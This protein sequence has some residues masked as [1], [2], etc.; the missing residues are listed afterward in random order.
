MSTAPQTNIALALMEDKELAKRYYAKFDPYAD[1]DTS[2]DTNKSVEQKD[3]DNKDAEKK[4]TEKKD[5][6]KE[7]GKKATDKEMGNKDT[8]KDDG[9]MC[10]VC[11][12]VI[13]K[14][15]MSTCGHA[16]CAQ[17]VNQLAQKPIQHC[18]I[19]KVPVYKAMYNGPFGG[20]VSPPGTTN[21]AT[22]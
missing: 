21:H 13:A 22:P 8:D 20:L 19:C 5:T 10:P 18:P 2:V 6:D 4:D 14:A 16:L 17:C 11:H 3:V 12:T 15:L 9:T 7:M 1:E